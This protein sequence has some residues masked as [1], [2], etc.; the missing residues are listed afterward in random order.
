[1][2][3][4]HLPHEQC[5]TDGS[6]SGILAA[7]ETAGQ[8]YYT[9]VNSKTMRVSEPISPNGKASRKHP[10]VVGNK[11]GETLLVWTENTGWGKGGAV[12]WRLFDSDGKTI[13]QENRAD[14]LPPWSLAAAFAETNDDFVIVY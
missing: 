11:R 9:D 6:A 12:G 8:G 13:S 5:D 1:M 3:G 4:K 14:G 7:W 2:E 10:V